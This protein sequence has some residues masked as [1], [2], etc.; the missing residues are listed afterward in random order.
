MPGR[1]DSLFLV[2]RSTDPA[3]N[4]EMLKGKIVTNLVFLA[5]LAPTLSFANSAAMTTEL[6]VSE[7]APYLRGNLTTNYRDA[8]LRSGIQHLTDAP[9]YM[10]AK[11]T[12]VNDVTVGQGSV[13][14]PVPVAL[15]I[16]FQVGSL[17]GGKRQ[18]TVRCVISLRTRS[19]QEVGKIDKT[20]VAK[21][22][23]FMGVVTGTTKAAIESAFKR[24]I[25]SYLAEART[26]IN[27]LDLSSS[28]TPP[29]VAGPRLGTLANISA[30]GLQ[31]A[32]NLK[33]VPNL[34]IGDSSML[35]LATGNFFDEQGN[36]IVT[37]YTNLVEVKV[38][39]ISGRS[40]VVQLPAAL[41]LKVGDKLAL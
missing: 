29:P 30:D 26:T 16:P 20:F 5:A 19:A 24:N 41:Q 35:K 7:I 2:S 25:G 11:L 23:E 18:V 38:I 31:L 22:A 34:K 39:G 15:P 6:D 4:K 1:R 14:I 27:R 40:V 3:R 12:I 28:A 32:I 9:I 13:G 17:F 33:D 10:D 8:L 21:R 36:L 37:G